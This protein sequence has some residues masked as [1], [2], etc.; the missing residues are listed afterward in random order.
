MPIRI[1]QLPSATL[2]LNTTDL[3]VVNQDGVTKTTDVGNIGT[4]FPLSRS[5]FT[6]E[7]NQDLAW[8][9]DVNS[10][11]SNDDFRIRGVY[12]D[13]CEGTQI[14]LIEA[15]LSGQ[16]KTAL[17]VDVANDFCL[18]DYPTVTIPNLVVTDTA[19]L[20]FNIVNTVT[21]GAGLFSAGQTSGNMTITVNSPQK[22]RVSTTSAL[23]TVE[24]YIGVALAQENIAAG[25]TYKITVYGTTTSSGA[26]TTSLKVKVGSAGSTSD[27]TILTAAIVAATSG[28]NVPWKAEFLITIRTTGSSGTLVT[29]GSLVNDGTTGIYTLPTKVFAPATGSINTTAS[30]KFGISLISTSA[31]TASTI[32]SAI[33]EML[34]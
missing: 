20:P 15:F 19:E 4:G 31:N 25:D 13:G 11:P 23:S 24:T 2:P 33:A 29:V 21:A 30:N 12:P 27:A 14:G 26:N 10:F 32:Y 9:G 3:V 28:T 5:Q 34:H 1:S 8:A 16:W 17:E 22:S 7:S 6:A 18:G